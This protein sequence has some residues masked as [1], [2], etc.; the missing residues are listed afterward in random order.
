MKEHDWR[1]MVLT[2]LPTL[3]LTLPRQMYLVLVL[4]Y[5]KEYALILLSLEAILLM[6]VASF[7]LKNDKSKAIIGAI[8]LSLDPV[9]G[10]MN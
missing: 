9:S 4:A 1:D 6:I 3:A 5:L 10:L 7:Y 2:F 8:H